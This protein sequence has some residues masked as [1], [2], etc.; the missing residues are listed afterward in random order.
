[1][2][3]CKPYD[4]D[5][6]FLVTI[7]SRA[8]LKLAS[9]AI[10]RCSGVNKTASLSNSGLNLSKAKAIISFVNPD[11]DSKVKAKVKAKAKAKLKLK[12]D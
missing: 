6:V 2:A 10:L 5:D 3:T 12:S 9:Q 1:M 4:D 11:V 7:C 8:I